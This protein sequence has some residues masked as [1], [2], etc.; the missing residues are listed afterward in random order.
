MRYDKRTDDVQQPIVDALRAAGVK[1]YVVGLPLDLM[2]AIPNPDRS[3]PYRTA[4][5]ECKDEDGRFTKPQLKFFE[6]WPGEWHVVRSP[7]EAL[8]ACFGD[9]MA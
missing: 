7:I 3:L 6:E 1:V 5:L 8:K 9:A 2:C 4:L